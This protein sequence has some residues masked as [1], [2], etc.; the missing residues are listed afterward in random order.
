[1]YCPNSTP[2]LYT[3]VAMDTDFDS[4]TSYSG[5]SQFYSVTPHK[6]WDSTSKQATATSIH[7]PS[8]SSFSYSTIK[9]SISYA[10]EKGLLN[11]PRNNLFMVCKK[12]MLKFIQKNSLCE[13]E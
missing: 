2:V 4:E 13:M 3:L 7:V 11:N 12:I 9:N 10:V 6:S 8:T 1:M 5:V